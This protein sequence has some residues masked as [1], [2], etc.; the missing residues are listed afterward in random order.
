MEHDVRN[1]LFVALHLPSRFVR[2]SGDREELDELVR[3]G[4]RDG[5]HAALGDRRANRG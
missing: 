5:V 4:V 3:R 2:R 1:H